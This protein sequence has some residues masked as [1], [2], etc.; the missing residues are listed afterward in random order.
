MRSMRMTIPASLVLV[1]AVSALGGSALAQADPTPSPDPSL[2]P[3]AAPAAELADP[4]DVTLPFRDPRWRKITPKRGPA[5][6]EDHTWTVDGDGRF[7]YLFGGRDG[8]KDKGDLWR[9]DLETD[10]W[11]RLS[12]KGKRPQPRFGHSAVWVDG[13]GVV[14]FAGQRGSD[15]FDDLWVFGPDTGKWRELPAKGSVPKRRY[16][17]C[18][19]VGPDGRLWI[20]HGFT[21]QGRFDDTRAYNLKSERWTTITPDGRKPGERCLHDCFTSAS[22]ELVLYGGQDDGAFALGDLWL[23]GADHAWQRQ[24]DPG[25]APRRLYALTEAGDYAYVFGGAGEDNSPFDDLW[26]VDRETLEFKRVKVEGTAPGARSAGTFITDPAR[27]RLLLFGGQGD[28]AKADLWELVDRFD[29][30]LEP[31]EPASSD[32]APTASPGPSPQAGA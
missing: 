29:A 22:G 2:E 1:F 9:Y 32:A 3:S 16:G 10:S 18:M 26:R 8:D 4:A 23:M 25:P 31:V 11:K 21:F 27:G 14:V 7:A 17:S 6:R 13:Y 19:V 20:S 28:D 24:G 30:A 15:F 12:P 5:A